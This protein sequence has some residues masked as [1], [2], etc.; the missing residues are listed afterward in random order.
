MRGLLHVASSCCA[1]V[2]VCTTLAL[3]CSLLLSDTCIGQVRINEILADPG[4]DWNGDGAIDFKNDEWVE[5]VNGGSDITSLENLRLSDGSQLTFRYG[6]SGFLA[7]G[8]RVVVYGSQSVAWELAN[9]WATAG[10]SL[11][12]AGDS[13]HLWH[14]TASDTTL[15][16]SYTYVSHEALKDRSTGR[17]PDGGDTWSIF[18]ALNPY[19]GTTPPLGTGCRPT[20]GIVNGCP[21]A[22][23]ASTWGAVKQLF[24]E[25]GRGAQPNGR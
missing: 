22:V 15:V 5:I 3:G 13:V 1:I 19:S 8:A 24:A 16:D 25:T 9:G 11:N 17:V 12:N 6:F 20:P 10:L 18:D 7:P 2:A 23:T 4:Q 21:T 14:V